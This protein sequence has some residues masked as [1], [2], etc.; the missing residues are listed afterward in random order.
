M[1]E[2]INYKT[3][4]PIDFSYKTVQYEEVQIGVIHI[5]VQRR[6]FYL[7]KDFA[8]LKKNEVHIRRGSS[9]AIASP[10]EISTMGGE[11]K[12]TYR[13]FPSLEAFLVS[14]KHDDIVEKRIARK[15]IN[16]KIPDDEQFPDYSIKRIDGSV[17]LSV[18][19]WDYYREKARYFQAYSRVRAFKL[20]I[21]NLGEVPA[22]DVKI[23]FDI[24]N[25]DKMSIVCKRDDLPDKPL[26]SKNFD[27]LPFKHNAINKT[28]YVA[29][30]TTLQ[31]WRVTC[32]LGK[33]QP[34]D[35]V[36]TN[37][38]FCLGAVISKS[39][40]INAQ[41]FSDDLPEPKQEMFMIDFEVEER[42][43]SVDDFLPK[44]KS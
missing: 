25:E 39:I 31:G 38:Y 27:G 10:D 18:G 42:I 15:L 30:K 26:K 44:E 6:P 2:F 3:Q 14:G 8:R 40:M 4:R 29:V 41:I 33:I 32:H 7:Q 21:R 35:M 34:K 43:Y 12:S 11:I 19:N 17:N 16:A 5:P 20:G 13:S 28:P 24:A 36:V 1:Q 22:R 37:D 23:V 9:T